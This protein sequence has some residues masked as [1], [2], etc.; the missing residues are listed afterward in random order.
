MSQ[1]LEEVISVSDLLLTEDLDRVTTFHLGVVGTNA[2]FASGDF[3]RWNWRACV[4]MYLEIVFKRPSSCC[5]KHRPRNICLKVTCSIVLYVSQP[6][7]TVQAYITLKEVMMTEIYKR[8][9][10][11]FNL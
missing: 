11:L 3:F 8:M 1:K 2:C 4:F 9:R 6:D 5:F 10:S 7:S